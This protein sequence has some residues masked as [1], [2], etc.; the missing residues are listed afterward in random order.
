[1]KLFL[2]VC[3]RPLCVN[4]AEFDSEELAFNAGWRGL[5]FIDFQEPYITKHAC[6]ECS[7]ELWKVYP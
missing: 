3:D 1:M 6:P 2:L 5:R 7:P 4:V